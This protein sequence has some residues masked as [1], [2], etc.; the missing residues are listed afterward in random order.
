[1]YLLL[2]LVEKRR[3][4]M[5]KE[6]KTIVNSVVRKGRRGF[7]GEKSAEVAQWWVVSRRFPVE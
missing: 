5:Q 7:N 2:R 4:E 1:V 3:E 6:G